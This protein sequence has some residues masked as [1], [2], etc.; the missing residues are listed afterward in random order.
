MYTLDICF[1]DIIQEFKKNHKVINKGLIKRAYEYA[2]EKHKNQ[3][4][5]KTGEPYILHPLRVAYHLASWG[6]DADV[7][8]SALLHDTLEDTDATYDDLVTHFGKNIAD[9]VDAVTAID[10]E[11]KDKTGLTK[12]EIDELSDTRLKE[13]MSERALFIKAA[14]RI[15][16]LK[17]IAPFSEEKKIAK[18]KHTREII[19]PMLMKEEAFQL[20]DTLEDLCLQIEHPKRYAEIDSSYTAL[21]DSNTYTTTRTLKLFSE[22]FSPNTSIDTAEYSTAL[23]SIVEFTYNP[24]STISVYRQINAQA[25]NIAADLP[26][27]LCKRNIAMFDLTLVISDDYCSNT[28]NT[29]TN[30]FFKLYASFLADSGITV[31]DFGLTTYKDS[32][33]YILCDEMGNRYRLFVKSETEYKRYKLGHIIDAEDVTDFGSAI[34][35]KKIKVYKRDE[36]AMYIEAGATFLDF[37]FAIHSEIGLHFNYATVDGNKTQR[38]PYE[39]ITEG[40]IISVEADPTIEP[41]LRWFKYVKTSKAMEHLIKYLSTT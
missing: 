40:D 31:L 19:I 26:K 38:K 35:G 15:D 1:E 27:L 22:V 39:K 37:A 16:N 32:K 18:A 28:K 7:I 23:R 6:F 13:R 12:E 34:D 14:D 30:V 3:K 10:K 8:C 20:I 25:N 5:R 9:M 4:P 33:Y 29:P 36:T 21:R 11:I 2:A 17:T 41:T 24:R